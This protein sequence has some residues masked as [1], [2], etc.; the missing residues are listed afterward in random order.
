MSVITKERTSHKQSQFRIY[1]PKHMK[2]KI[3]QFYTQEQLFIINMSHAISVR[4]PHM[5]VN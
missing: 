4:T 2:N 1:L 5:H 3:I